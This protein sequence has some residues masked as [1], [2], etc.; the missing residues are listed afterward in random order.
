ML[1]VISLTTYMYTE[2]YSTC[3]NIGLYINKYLQYMSTHTYMYI[4]VYIYSLY[5][6]VLLFCFNLLLAIAP[7]WNK[8][9]RIA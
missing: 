1:H 5:M 6:Y 7:I 9:V 4:H 2:Q 8:P 3:I